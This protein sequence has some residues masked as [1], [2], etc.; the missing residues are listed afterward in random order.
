MAGMTRPTGR[1]RGGALRSW[2]GIVVILLLGLASVLCYLAISAT[3]NGEPSTAPFNGYLAVLQTA[4]TFSTDQIDLAAAPLVPGGPGRHP[5]LLYSLAVCGGQ[6]FSGIL[7]V[8]GDARLAQPTTTPALGSP[9]AIA[10][11][12]ITDVPHLAFLD[13]GK[14]AVINLGAAQVI[15]LHVSRPGRCESAYSRRQT[16]P[17]FLG[18]AQIITGRAAAPVQRHWLAGWWAGPRASQSW[19][20]VGGLPGVSP[21][22]V[23]A[24]R[25]LSGLRGSWNLFV[26]QYTSVS[27]GTLGSRGLVEQARPQL[28]SST[29]LN[30]QS[31][32]QLQPVAVISDS[33][34]LSAWQNWLVAAGV[35][36]GI[37][38]SLLASLLYDLA[39]PSRVHSAPND[40][41][42]PLRSRGREVSATSKPFI[43]VA[44]MALVFWTASRRRRR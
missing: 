32:Q 8:G 3:V 37:G 25:A 13:E 40:R 1:A 18:R 42:E 30:W 22:D 41:T 33:I 39:R 43:V 21:Q 38:A 19:P 28:A 27:V 24:F 20:L 2:P 5:A 14:D 11:S 6:P 36:L 35:F 4:G 26:R 34:A 15:R 29:N 9:T 10:R 44:V 7:V 31:K 23:G 12:G 16:P 17:P